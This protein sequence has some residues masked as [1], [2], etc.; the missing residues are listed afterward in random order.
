MRGMQM[1]AIRPTGTVR[2]ACRGETSP[3]PY[4]V[5]RLYLIVGVATVLLAL[6]V[7]AACGGP[8]APPVSPQPTE[9]LPP[10]PTATLGPPTVVPTSTAS[11]TTPPLTRI[12]PTL[13]PG[14]VTPPV[15]LPEGF[16]ILPE[17]RFVAYQP[18]YDP[19][20]SGE[21]DCA[22]GRTV[23]EL[24][25]YDVP[26]PTSQMGPVPPHILVAQRYVDLLKSA[27]YTVQSQTSPDTMLLTVTGATEAP[28]AYA[29][30]V[31]GPPVSEHKPPPDTL[32]VGVRISVMRRQ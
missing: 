29:E 25:L 11:P 9:T 26:L 32:W 31:V 30:I 15:P 8:V 6:V 16:P 21:R 27:G 17:A 13:P 28:V 10:L 3:R 14:V 2:Y 5:R 24:W 23:F 18:D 1:K 22:P 12:P 20:L 7:L 4:G 19:C